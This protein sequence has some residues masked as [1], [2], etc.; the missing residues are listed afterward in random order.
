M[1]SREIFD[2]LI[3]M[4]CHSTDISDAFDAANPL[5]D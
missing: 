4:G 1:T 5:L 2:K 3:G